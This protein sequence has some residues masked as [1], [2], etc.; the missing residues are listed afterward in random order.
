MRRSAQCSSGKT[1][2]ELIEMDSRFVR[3]TVAAMGAAAVAIAMSAAAGA[4]SRAAAPLK[5]MVIAPVATPI[6]NYPDAPAGADAAAAAINKAGGIKGRKVEVSFCNTQ[7]QANVATACARQAVEQGVVAVVGHGS[8]LTPLEEPIL[9]SAGIPDVGN[10]SFAS[11]TDWTNPN[12]FPR[13]GGS[14]ASV[15]ALPFA[16]K[17]L[18]KKRLVI[19]TTDVPNSVYNGKLVQSAA[20][21]AKLPLV[22]RIVVPGSTTDFSPYAQ[23]MRDLN[24]DSVVLGGTAG[25]AGG[26]MRATYSLG[27]RPLWSHNAGSIGEPEADQIGPPADGMLLDA[28]F[29]S[30]RDTKYPGIRRWVSEMKAAGK[31]DT[32]LLKPLAVNSWLALHGLAELA[33]TIKGEVTNVSLT[34]ALRKQTKPINLYG[35]VSW[36]PGRKGPAAYPRW[37]SPIR[38]YFSTIKNGQLVAYPGLGPVEPLRAQRFVR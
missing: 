9:Q 6:Q 35:L 7:S 1:Q 25:V 3:W 15:M 17:K 31:G 4:S 30:Y 19:M 21:A 5:V 10:W 12:M 28:P 38:Y 14:A 26:F 13:T 22:G 8:T 16:L 18:G 29:P 20:R 36:A 27:V 34:A 23:K 32:S 2:G 24:P 37:G 33:K 11:P